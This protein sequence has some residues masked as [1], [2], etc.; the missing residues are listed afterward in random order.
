MLT[1]LLSSAFG[2]ETVCA[3]GC[4]HTTVQNAIAAA[5][6][7]EEVHILEP[8]VYDTNVVNFPA[9]GIHVIGMTAGIRLTNFRI[10]TVRGGMGLERVSIDCGGNRLADL[11]GNG[12]SLILDFVEVTNCSSSSGGI[13]RTT[14]N[15]ASLTIQNSW[16]HDVSSTGSGGVVT[17]DRGTVVLQHNLV[18]DASATNNGGVVNRTSMAGNLTLRHNIFVGNT[19]AE[20][21]VLLDAAGSGASVTANTF[22]SGSAGANRGGALSLPQ[23][24]VA[25]VDNAFAFNAAGD[26][27]ADVPTGTYTNN[28]WWSNTAEDVNGGGSRG[29]AAVTSNP[30]FPAGA[31]E[32]DPHTAAPTAAAWTTGS[33]NGGEIGAFRGGIAIGIGPFAWDDLDGDGRMAI[34]DC[35]DNEPLAND[36]QAELPCDGIDND[37]DGFVDEGFTTYYPDLDGDGYG[38][39]A[40]QGT[41]PATAFALVGGD[42]DDGAPAVN[43][44]ANEITCNGIDD[45]CS[46]GT[47]DE[48]DLDNDGDGFCTDCDDGDP[49]NSSI[50]TEVCDGADNDCDTVADNGLTFDTWYRDGDGDG[51][52]RIPG[53]QS[54]CAQPPGWV[55][56]T[57][58]CADNDPAVNPGASELTCNGVDDDCSAATPDGEDLDGD[59]SNECADCNDSDPDNF[60][61]NVESCDGQD[62]DC[63]GLADVAGPGS[64]LDADSDGVRRCENDC[65]D[66]D[67]TAYPGAPELCDGVDNDCNGTADAAGGEADSDSDSWRTCDGDCDDADPFAYPGNPEVCDGADNDCMG[68]VDDGLVFTDYFPDGDS[69]GY[70]VAPPVSACSAQA[71]HALVGGDCND[72]AANVNPGEVEICDAIDHDC[73]GDPSNDVVDRD[74]YAD[75]DGDGYGDPGAFLATDCAAPPDSAADHS[76]CDDGDASVHPGA[77]EVCNGVDD[78]CDTA[79]DQGLPV[80]DYYPDVDGDGAG[81]DSANPVSAC[82]PVAGLVAN[83]DDCDDSA[84]SI[85]LGAAEVCDDIDNDCDGTADEGLPQQTS[86]VDTDGDGYGDDATLVLDCAVAP[87]LV[88][89][90]GDCEPAD[91]AIHPGAA[92]VCDGI[93]QD[94]DGDVDDGLATFD[95]YADLDG[96]G[97][98]AGASIGADCAVAPDTSATAG[99]CDDADDTTYPGAIEQC[100]SVDNDCDG[101]VD[102]DVATTDWFTDA[103]GDGYGAGPA[104]PDCLQPSGTV[105]VAGDCDDADSAV[106]PGAAEICDFEDNDCDG[107]EDDDDPD[108]T[109]PAVYPDN[110]LDGYGASGVAGF[111]ACTVPPGYAT[112]STDCDD[113]DADI[114]PNAVEACPDGIDNDCDGLVDADDPSYSEQPVTFWFDQ[115][116]DGYG[117]PALTFT[118]CSGDEPLGYVSPANGQDCDDAEFSTNPFAA[119]V[120]DDI[121]NDCDALVDEGIATID[122]YPDL[123]GDGFGDGGAAPEAACSANLPRVLGLIPDSQDCDDGDALINPLAPED[124]CDGIDEDCDGLVDEGLGDAVWRD[125]DGDGYGDPGDS[126]FQCTIEPGWVLNDEDC[127]DTSAEVAPD[128]AELCNGVDD[129]CDLDIDEGVDIADQTLFW[130]DA[131]GDGFGDA[132][133]PPL[134]ACTMPD[135]YVTDSTDCDDSDPD[136]NVECESKRGTGCNCDT[137]GAPAALWLLAFAGLAALRRRSA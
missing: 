98:G 78:D 6:Q 34:W 3:S 69:D 79:V 112:S 10:G 55:L 83:S 90:G 102:D 7:N 77:T 105:A 43:P 93:D 73:D 30:G 36:L 9:N 16:V 50:G 49:D 100:D 60:P 14:H 4:N 125:A 104:I 39:G 107:L 58:D 85:Y 136:Q 135:G 45:D 33:S 94:C 126:A 113:L 12:D 97:Y 92:E 24:N 25:V 101:V 118:G 32:C 47:P 38:T 57:G 27:L 54:A 51:Y 122:Y 2:V 116:G 41:C 109:A 96:D 64:E 88:T 29:T 127:D 86:Y 106:S 132:G 40:G 15:G 44:G 68:G 119:E 1:F 120:C 63:D 114:R 84:P 110:D 65:D 5:S 26:A 31:P 28:G 11:G 67:P 99:D 111:P 137:S 117:T 13:A 70:G 21:G 17:Q 131:D 42:C 52:G 74:W 76:D 46:A 61:G 37:C 124:D 81:D 35:D 134:A 59:G 23:T 48:Q 121:D 71:G 123:D 66:A 87:G 89:V 53:P 75:L 56:V 91:D 128:A 82:G 80:S 130:P 20:G 133:S 19:A 22:F 115:D 103:D 129:D 62:N 72:A 8:G 95:L 108:L 18:C